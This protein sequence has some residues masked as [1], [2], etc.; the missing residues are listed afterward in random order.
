MADSFYNDLCD[1]ILTSVTKNIANFITLHHSVKEILLAGSYDSLYRT[2]IIKLLF[3][4]K[5]VIT[6]LLKPSNSSF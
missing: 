2:P 4:I 5:N 1:N 3:Y 6:M